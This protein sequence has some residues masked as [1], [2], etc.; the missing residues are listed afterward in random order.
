[1]EVARREI[2]QKVG[3]YVGF[4]TPPGFRQWPRNMQQFAYAISVVAYNKG[5][6]FAIVGANIRIDKLSLRPCELSHPALI[7]EISKFLQA[8]NTQG[9][10]QL[11]FDDTT[12]IDYGMGMAKG[13]FDTT[14]NRKLREITDEE[15]TALKSDI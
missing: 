14:G 13:T 1:M 7:A 2:E 15:R 4:V 9:S 8:W 5:T 10:M 12:A 6:E 11:T 3:S